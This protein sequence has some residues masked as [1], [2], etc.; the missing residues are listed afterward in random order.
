MVRI[1]KPL[2]RAGSPV[3]RI[4]ILVDIT[5]TDQ[6]GAPAWP[7]E[8]F[9]EYLR[10]L[11]RLQLDPRLQG[12]LDPSDVVQQTLLK[13]HAK[14]DQFRGTTEAEF[15]A[16]LRHILA[17]NLAE[18]TRRFGTAARDVNLERSLGEALDASAARLEACL[19]AGTTTPS[20]H[21]ARNE[22]VLRLS[23]ALALLPDDQRRAVEL[24]HLRGLSSPEVARLMER[25]QRSV[26]GL[27]LRGMRQLRQLLSEE[28]P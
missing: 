12:K 10:M 26:A 14:H 9:R 4:L 18:E 17:N 16:W 11:A 23:A 8:R 20:E 21:A 2:S 13:A 1:K 22:Q 6:T 15:T 28:E 24:H 7:L 3:Q 5:M 19:S 27:L 25:T